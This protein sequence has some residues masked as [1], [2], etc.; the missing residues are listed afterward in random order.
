MDLEAV[1][2]R[3]RQVLEPYRGRLAVAADGPGGVSLHLPG[4]ADQ[5]YGYVAGIRKLAAY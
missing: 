2:R 5:P 1:D 4:L 3:L